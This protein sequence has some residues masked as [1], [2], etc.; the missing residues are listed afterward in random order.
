[1]VYA[2]IFML[3]VLS[4]HMPRCRTTQGPRQT[5]RDGPVRRRPDVLTCRM[6]HNHML[7]ILYRTPLHS[8]LRAISYDSKR[9]GTPAAHGVGFTC[10]NREGVDGQRSSYKG[11][12]CGTAIPATMPSR[13]RM[14][15]VTASLACSN[16][17]L[18]ELPL[19]MSSKKEREK[20]R[21]APSS[22]RVLQQTTVW[23]P[24]FLT[25]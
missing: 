21:A 23:T 2:R 25:A 24:A 10:V 14:M 22:T 18:A 13:F 20:M 12:F 6:M 1:M 11:T 4:R 8:H 16:A 17:S 9:T 15:D 3:I 19:A 5:P 7:S